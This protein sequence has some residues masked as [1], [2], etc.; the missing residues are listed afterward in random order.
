M[1]RAIDSSIL[2][3]L[4]AEGLR[5]FALLEF[6]IDST[7]YRYTD[8]DV[9][10]TVNGNVYQPRGF[11]QQVINYGSGNIVDQTSIDIDNL[12]QTLT[13]VF[14]GGTPQGSDCKIMMCVLDSNYDPIGTT[15]H[16]TLF[17][18]EI[19]AWQLAEDI[20]NLTVTNQFAQWS[21]KT[22][23]IHSASCRWKVFKGTECAY[24]GDVSV[25]DRTYE[26]C[27]SYGNTANFGGYRYLPSLVDKQ[28]WWGSVQG[29]GGL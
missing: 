7:G 17:E 13:A 11:E 25:C 2:A 27:L 5:P 6:T 16:V 3:E 26:Q 22:L 12:D 15:D 19:G 24:S 9:P 18:G 20:I 14:V 1:A 21:Q 10:V 29:K 4:E 8:C 23:S 28:V